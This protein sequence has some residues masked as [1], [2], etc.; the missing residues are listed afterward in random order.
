MKKIGVIVL[1][2]VALCGHAQGIGDWFNQKKTKIKLLKEQIVACQVYIGYVEKGYQI[3]SE[4][5]HTIQDLKN[6]EFHLHADYFNRLQKVNP[7][8]KKMAEITQ[9]IVNEAGIIQSFKR[10]LSSWKASGWLNGD[11]I[12]YCAGVYANLAA[13]AA[14]NL[15]ALLAVTTDGKLQMTDDER[16][17]AVYK[18]YAETS[19][20]ALFAQ[21]FINSNGVLI[22][23]RQ[24]EG[25]GNKIINGLYNSK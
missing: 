18:I 1:V 5:L 21:S 8:I 19:D 2:L 16:I 6:G 4:G 15:D 20:Q 3:A 10:A 22:G 17:Q 24:R 13:E 14:K 25:H 7:K 12:V 11:E 9:V 23:Q